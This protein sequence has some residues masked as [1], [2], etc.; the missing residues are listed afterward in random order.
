MFFSRDLVRLDARCQALQ[1]HSARQREALAP[2]LRQA[3]QPLAWADQARQ[4]ARAGMAGLL[5]A[6][7]LLVVGL[8]A[9][10]GLL[11]LRR[12]VRSLRFALRWARR[13]WFAWRGWRRWQ[14]MLA[15]PR[16]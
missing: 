9:A 16:G 12:P 3:A 8:G 2:V 5:Q 15:R 1:Q 10:L 4:A 11:V 7:P 6:P 13:G 14:A